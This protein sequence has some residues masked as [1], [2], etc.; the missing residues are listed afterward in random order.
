MK[1][2]IK[3]AVILMINLTILSLSLGLLTA[4]SASANNIGMNLTSKLTESPAIP[5]LAVGGPDNFG[6]TYQDE[7]EAFGP[8]YV[9]TNISGS[10]TN[11]N[12]SDESDADLTTAA[13]LPGFDFQFYGLNVHTLRVGNN[14]AV[15][16]N[17]LIDER[18]EAGNDS[19]PTRYL[20]APWWDDWDTPGDVYWQLLGSGAD[21]YLIIQWNNMIHYRAAPVGSY[22]QTVT[23]QAILY[24]RGDLIQFQYPDAQAEPG[25]TPPAVNLGSAGTIGIYSPLSGLEY[26]YNTPVLTN[27]RAIRFQHSSITIVKDAI[28]TDPQDFQFSGSAGLSSTFSL[29]DDADLTLSNR[30]TFYIVPGLYAITETLPSGWQLSDLSCDSPHATPDQL[31]ASAAITLAPEDELTCTFENTKLGAVTIVKEATPQGSQPFTFTGDFGNFN[32]T[33][34]GAPS[35]TVSFTDL[36]PS[37]YLITETVPAN[38]SLTGINCTGGDYTAAIPGVSVFLDPGEVITC[39]FANVQPSTVIIEKVTEPA[40]ETQNFD[41]S[42]TISTTPTFTLNPGF[43]PISQTLAGLTPGVHRI[44]E[45]TVTGWDLT[46]LTCTDPTANSTIISPTAIINTAPGETVTCT[47]TNTRRGTIAIVKDAVPNYSQ[48]FSFTASGP[49]FIP[50]FDLDDDPTS[51]TPNTLDFS[52]TPG[53]YTITETNVSDWT[54]SAIDCIDPTSNSSGI[55]STRQANLDVA[56]GEVV[57]CT[58]TNLANPAELI[59]EKVTDPAAD[60]QTFTFTTN[61]PG[62]STFTL[63]TAGAAPLSR[64]FSITTGNYS[65]SELPV[66]GWEATASACS[67]GSAAGSID[68]QPGELVTCTFTNTKQAELIVDKVT[69]PSGNPTP[70]DFRLTG[71]PDNEN[72][73]FSLTDAA[74]PRSSGFISSGDSY[75]ITETVPSGWALTSTCSDS[76]PIDNVDLSPGEVVTCT[77]TNTRLGQIVVDKVTQPAGNTTSF[78]FTATNLSPTT[79]SLTDAATPQLFANVLPGS[80]YAITE[81]VPTNW[82]LSSVNC[83]DGSPWDNIDVSPGE[84]ITC[85][86]TNTADPGSLII[87]KVTDPAGDAQIFN[88][89]SNIPGNN[90]FTLSTGG[91]APLS[92]TFTIT[93]ATYSV[94]EQALLGWAAESSCS[95]TSDVS[96][97]SVDA[98]ETVTCTFTNTRQSRIFVDKVTNPAGYPTPFQFSLT[99][100]P[101]S[102]SRTFTLTDTQPVYDSDFIVP[103][104]YS[105]TETPATGWTTNST[106]T[107]GHAATGMNLTAGE[108]VTC[109]FTNIAQ[110][111]VLTV[112]KRAVPA[113]GSRFTFSVTGQDDFTLANGESQNYPSL[114]P[115]AYRILEGALPGWNLSTVLCDDPNSDDGQN[116]A[117]ITLD[118]GDHVTCVF[119]NTQSAGLGSITIRKAVASP[120]NSQL[121]TFTSSWLPPFTLVDDGTTANTRVEPSLTPG[122]YVVTETAI[123]GWNLTGLTCQGDQDNGSSINQAARQVSIDVDA[124]EAIIC[125]FTN[126]QT[127]VGDNLIYLPIIMKNNDGSVLPLPI[128]LIVADVRLSNLGPNTGEPVVITATLR[129]TTGNAFATPFWVDLYLATSQINPAVNQTW[130]EGFADTLVPY[131]VAWKVSGSMF[132]GDVLTITNRNPNDLTAVNCNNY[133]NFIPNGLGCWPQTWKGIPLNNYF[134]NPGTYYLYVLADSFSDP[135]GSNVNGNVVE[136]NE[137]NNRYGPIPIVV[138]G[139]PLPATAP[140]SIQEVEIPAARS[141]GRAPIQP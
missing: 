37:T 53:S 33:D 2:V 34:D 63:S 85:T 38:W 106:C 30:R 67:D 117:L 77:F 109:T 80:G 29:D 56:A 28:P 21:Q 94:S 83:I 87:E 89:N 131:G 47:Y 105:V 50:P 100:G 74:A 97:I 111:G 41:F 137:T 79:F 127:V 7:V 68:L 70:F 82:T 103:G 102:I 136:T 71:G 107:G 12:L 43:G 32:L 10:G 5:L 61:L 91:A 46:G 40:S 45:S 52:V 114:P 65:V 17:P 75:N 20:I 54:L 130:D 48:N 11:L 92:R 121:F 24:E 126:Q 72:Q 55:T 88:F 26:G 120:P 90:T 49:T 134:R 42:T 35:N 104:V 62:N 44:T 31:Q 110:P 132:A 133:S 140:L 113:D 115:G 96:S 66:I 18:V 8:T 73:N 23:F 58:F 78:A 69:D 1:R 51:G 129:N 25:P 27:S 81:T 108:V 101:T 123:S 93:P 128:D 99:G 19:M 119:T 141:Q 118:P 39:T 84:V 122:V 98:G 135:A 16:V 60:P 76:S 36:S 57:T 4:L 86:F 3:L 14:G 13:N 138:G 22:S 6:Y 64:T 15:V 125:T 124:G 139:S 116:P 59:V 112:T 9:F 95:D